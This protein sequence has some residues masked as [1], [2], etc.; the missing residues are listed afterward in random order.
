MG[1]GSRESLRCDAAFESTQ[2]LI[3][4]VIFIKEGIRR[5]F[6]YDNIAGG[7]FEHLC[8]LGPVKGA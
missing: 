4:V 6:K 2:M 7:S 5:D 1:E 3:S 8:L